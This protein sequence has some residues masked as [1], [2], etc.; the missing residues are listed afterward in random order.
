MFFILFFHLVFIDDSVQLFHCPY[1][2]R[3]VT[4]LLYQSKID[5]AMY[6]ENMPIQVNT[7]YS[8]HMKTVMNLF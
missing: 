2:S 4:P 1:L 6:D 3:L 5:S 8:F 7:Q